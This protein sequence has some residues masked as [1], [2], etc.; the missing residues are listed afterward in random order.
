MSSDKNRIKIIVALLAFLLVIFLLS[1]SEL[2]PAIKAKLVY[3][4]AASA[5]G[6]AEAD[7]N[8]ADGEQS[9]TP[10][11]QS[12]DNSPANQASE[13]SKLV[14][15]MQ[16][17]GFQEPEHSLIYYTQKP[18]PTPK[19]TPKPTP[20]PTPKPTPKPTSKPTPKPTSKPTPKPTAKPTETPTVTEETSAAE[21]IETAA[22]EATTTQSD[23]ETTEALT[24]TPDSET[25]AEPSATE[26]TE[27]A[28][29]ASEPAPEKPK[30]GVK[31]IAFTFD[32]GPSKHTKRL[33][34]ALAKNGD[35]VTFF[36][37]GSLV[38]GSNGHLTTRAFKAGHEIGN[39]SYTHKN[40]RKLTASQIRDELNRTDQ[41][42]IKRTGAKPTLMRPP[43][44]AL[45]KTVLK[46]AGRPV[47]IWN[48]DTLD[49]R[50]KN[51]SYVK[52]KVLSMASDGSIVLLHDLHS[53]SVSGFIDALPEL[54]RRGYK[55]V[56]VSE[57]MRIKGIKMQAGK[58]YNSAR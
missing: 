44:G 4:P 8:A 51:R 31:Y 40:M 23:G 2:I 14:A 28:T 54:H 49:W 32:D 53:T 34:D 35:K 48:K 39:H 43:G 15:K 41:A 20:N 57:L 16:L 5:N 29:Q 21:L 33:L 10:V 47:I 46:L 30:K 7:I 22:E 11:V 56:T 45:N 25:S 6:A 12:S 3:T 52:N 9:T 19:P 1:E 42:V 38:D 17:P 50:N 58:K 26:A 27:A 37:V 13:E 36:V 55:L 18:T 24:S